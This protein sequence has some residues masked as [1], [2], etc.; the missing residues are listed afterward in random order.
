M[1][2]PRADRSP[3]GADLSQ[4]VTEPKMLYLTRKLGESVLIDENIEVTV[5]EV[6][7]RSIKLGFTFPAGVRCSGA[8]YMKKSSGKIWKRRSPTQICWLDPNPR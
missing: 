5:V 6:R 1:N 7:G 3:I 8:S 2:A 4:V